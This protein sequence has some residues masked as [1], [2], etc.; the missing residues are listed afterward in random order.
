MAQAIAQ[1][2]GCDDVTFELDGGFALVHLTWSH[3]PEPLPLFH[4]NLCHTFA[5]LHAQTARA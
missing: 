2:F 1:R 5:A 4:A 3:R